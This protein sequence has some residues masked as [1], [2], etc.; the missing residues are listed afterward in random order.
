MSFLWNCIL[1]NWVLIYYLLN[2]GLTL[3]LVWQIGLIQNPDSKAHQKRMLAM[4][5]NHCLSWVRE[6]LN[7]F[8]FLNFGETIIKC[9]S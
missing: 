7:T 3:E 9:P 4:V 6:A 2:K 8:R 5:N 1:K